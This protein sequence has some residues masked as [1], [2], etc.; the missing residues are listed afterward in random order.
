[1]Y[2]CGC[3][4]PPLAFPSLPAGGEAIGQKEPTKSLVLIKGGIGR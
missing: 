3:G 4:N 1:M 2:D